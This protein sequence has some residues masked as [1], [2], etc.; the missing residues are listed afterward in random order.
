MNCKKNEIHVSKHCRKLNPGEEP[1]RG[2][3]W[4]EMCSLRQN[5]PDGY[6][7]IPEHCRKPQPNKPQPKKA[8]PAKRR[9]VTV[10]KSSRPKSST[11]K[12][13]DPAVYENVIR[14]VISEMQNAMTFIRVIAPKIARGVKYGDLAKGTPFERNQ[15]VKDSAQALARIIKNRLVQNRPST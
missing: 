13:L 4:R 10:R 8:Q 1:T 12:C 5:G 11:K 6:S 9:I 2:K 15:H 3:A 14:N 7:F